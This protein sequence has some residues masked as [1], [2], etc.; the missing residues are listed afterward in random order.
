MTEKPTN[1]ERLIKWVTPKPKIQKNG[2]FK[3][4]PGLLELVGALTPKNSKGFATL[5]A[6]I[7]AV[8]M[9]IMTGG[10]HG[11]GWFLI[12]LWAIH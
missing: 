5:I 8:T 1:I 12:F 11:A 9:L 10:A 2:F 4:K 7:V 3:E 6:G